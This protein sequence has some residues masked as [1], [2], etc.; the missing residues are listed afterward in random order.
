MKNVNV[1]EMMSIA[2]NKAF[3]ANFE[4]ALEKDTE[5][6]ALMEKSN[7]VEDMFTVASK[8]FQIKLED[9]KEAY[10]KA[11]DYLTQP[12]AQLDDD[13]MDCVVGG[14]IGD[15]FKKHWHTIAAVAI[16]V[17]GVAVGALTCG[18]GATLIAGGMA[19]TGIHAIV[20][21]GLA[22]AGG[23]YVAGTAIDDA[24]HGKG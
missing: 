17:V 16:G 6:V 2:E 14:G 11:V 21:G 19:L 8:Y 7:S 9:F 18:V 4:A 23:T 22:I 24:V 13:I 15:W 12:K 5:A 1:A 3:V 20:G 10:H